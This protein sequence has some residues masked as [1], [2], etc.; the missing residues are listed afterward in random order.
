MQETA[1]EIQMK[2]IVTQWL[3]QIKR[4]DA[5]KRGFNEIAYQCKAFAG[6]KSSSSFMW[7]SA[8]K[9]KYIGKGIKG[10]KFEVGLLKGHEY[11]TIMGPLL[12]WT[13]PNRRIQSTRTKNINPQYLI[14]ADPREQEYMQMLQ[15]QQE[16]END[17]S[18]TRCQLYE[19]VLNYLQREQPGG[20]LAQHSKLAINE[21]L[22]KGRGV[23]W[24]EKY[25]FPGSDRNLVGSFYDTVSNLFIDPD[26]SD[27]TLTNAKWICR[28]RL[29][30]YW[31][32]EK[33]FKLPK[34]YLRNK[35]K[36]ESGA[37]QAKATSSGKKTSNPNK[38][39]IEWYEIYSKCGVGVKLDNA[40]TSLDEAWDEICGDYCYLAICEN[41]NS[42]LNAPYQRMATEDLS[43][44]EVAAMFEWPIP[45]WSDDKWPMS[46]LD[47]YQDDNTCW[48]I[49]PLAASL[50]EL[51]CLN[52][53]I[54]CYV[55][56]AYETRQQIVAYMSSAAETVEAAL[57]S[58][59]STIYVKLNDSVQRSINEVVGFL[60]RPEM[61]NNLLEAIQFLLKRFEE[62]SG[63]SE[64]LFGSQGIAVDRTAEASRNRNDRASIRPDYMAEVV[65]QW[66]T[67]IAEKEKIALRFCM[68]SEDVAPHLGP[69]GAYAW[70]QLI[71]MEDPE[72]VVRQMKCTVASSDMRRPDRAREVSNLQQL[73]NQ[74]LPV[75]S[76]ICATT[77]DY[78][79]LNAFLTDIGDSMEKDVSGWLIN[80]QEPDPEQ[81]QQQ[82]MLQQAMQSAELEKLESKSDANR[83]EAETKRSVAGQNAQESQMAGMDLQGKLQ[84]KA[85]MAQ[86]KMMDADKMNQLKMQTMSQGNQQKM[87][88]SDQMTQAKISSLMQGSQQKAMILEQMNQL[89]MQSMMQETQQKTLTLD[90]MNQ[91]KMQNLMQGS[92]QKAMTSQQMNQMMLAKVVEETQQKMQIA[93]QQS[94]QK[95]LNNAA[96]TFQKMGQRRA[97]DTLN[98]QIKK[99]TP[100]TN[101]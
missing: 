7:K 88:S 5:E 93:G 55:E 30:P 26:C 17:K 18:V 75:V 82:E 40:P 65:S 1:I 52:I 46:Q 64:V 19:D 89:K 84:L 11:L 90:Q 51:T 98:K 97:E 31:E 74:M 43:D 34:N 91:L 4:A 14:S 35:G 13:Y 60:N 62:R 83:A 80:I 56:Q 9:E 6:G 27:P 20:G 38:D 3:S 29:T 95:Q 73:A 21:A 59:S 81:Q 67:M 32:V 77:G 36:Y 37:S 66:Q 100:K 86:Q 96:I 61:N 44:E 54:S 101:G 22:L 50:G 68:T 2:K 92:E 39:L 78:A 49:A 23:V 94:Q 63:L 8:Y 76:Q 48:P 33:K 70:R 24:T 25:N 16:A 28:R 41:V 79:P 69:M 99:Q 10:P 85:A 72:I 45:L 71:E 57:K 58:D 53:L 87:I 15:Q 47:F 12:Y 42:P